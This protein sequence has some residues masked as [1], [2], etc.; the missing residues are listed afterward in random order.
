MALNQ[1]NSIPSV[2]VGMYANILI[3]LVYFQ[4]IIEW[5]L[6]KNPNHIIWY[7]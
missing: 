2:Y 1:S 4:L 3:D 7:I 5:I 6:E